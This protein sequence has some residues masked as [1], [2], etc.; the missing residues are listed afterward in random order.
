MKEWELKATLLIKEN[1]PE[2]QVL[3]ML[4]LEMKEVGLFA[5]EHLTE[6]RIGIAQQIIDIVKDIK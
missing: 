2:Y 4:Q 5:E 6:Q 1:I 3:D